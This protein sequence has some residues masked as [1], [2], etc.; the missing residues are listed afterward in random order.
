MSQDS[1]VH[2]LENMAMIRHKCVFYLYPQ[3]NV[4][5]GSLD[6]LKKKKKN[7]FLDLKKC[8]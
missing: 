4:N 3:K 8:L 5:F 6:L 7:K 2:I 1:V